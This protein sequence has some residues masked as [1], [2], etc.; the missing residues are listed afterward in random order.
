MP[1]VLD[2]YTHDVVFKLGD[3]GKFIEA[4]FGLVE[5]AKKNKV[6]VYKILSSSEPLPLDF[7]QDF[8][9]FM[10]TIESLYIKYE[11]IPVILSVVKQPTILPQPLQEFTYSDA[12]VKIRHDKP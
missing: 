12:T 9:S 10:K 4:E 11:G 1:T 5:D 7:H 6:F 3:G 2:I 8:V